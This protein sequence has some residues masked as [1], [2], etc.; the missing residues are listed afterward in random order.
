VYVEQRIEVVGEAGDRGGE[1]APV[2]VASRSAA[3]RAASRVG[4]SRTEHRWATT[5]TADSSGSLA[6]MLASRWNQQQILILVGKD[7]PIAFAKPGAPSLVT[8][9]AAAT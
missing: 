8:V 7:I 6:Q 4:A 9:G 3:A 2:G 1:L 5:S